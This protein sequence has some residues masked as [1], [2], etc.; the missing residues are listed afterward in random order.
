MCVCV[1]VC[2]VC[3]CVNARASRVCLPSDWFPASVVWPLLVTPLNFFAPALLPPPTPNRLAVQY[4]TSINVGYPTNIGCSFMMDAPGAWVAFNGT[5]ASLSMEICSGDPFGEV[6]MNVAVYT[7]PV[8][9]AV[10]GQL[11]ATSRSTIARPCMSFSLGTTSVAY[12]YTAAITST[13]GSNFTT[14]LTPDNSCAMDS[15]PITQVS[16][17]R[18]FVFFFCFVCFLG[19]LVSVAVA[20]VAGANHTAF[21]W[22]L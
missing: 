20:A 18:F 4:D 2:G 6:T 11:C 1:C 8:G 16:T 3:V 14:I 10:C 13:G 7:S 22:N 9:A 21:G 15:N 5:G 19:T 17:D 12:T